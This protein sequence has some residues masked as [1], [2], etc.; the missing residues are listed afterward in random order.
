V[1][2]SKNKQRLSKERKAAALVAARQAAERRRRLV[3]LGGIGIAMVVIA[4]TV[5]VVLLSKDNG[6]SSDTADAAATTPPF[7]YGTGACA[8]VEGKPEK[9][10]LTFPGTNGFEKCVDPA[11][12]YTATFTTT[13]GTVVVQLD[14]ATQPG[15]VNNFVQLAG[16][17]YYDGSKLFRTDPSIGIVQGGAPQT[18]SATDP[19]PG[20]TIT[21]E[22]SGFTYQPGQ[23]VMARTPNP[24]SAGSQFFFTVTDASSKLDDAGT[25]VVFGS[26][27]TGLD[28]LEQI[29]ASNVEGTDGLGGSP[30]PP[31]T[32][33]S[34]VI[35]EG[36]LVGST[37]TSVN[38][39]TSTPVPSSTPSST[40]VPSSTSTP[41]SSS[42]S[43][44]VDPSV[45][46]PQST[47]STSIPA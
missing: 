19:G 36:R 30:N 7:T 21:D 13:A 39:S 46:T 8:P 26:V 2:T 35:G 4:V 10:Q 45:S 33:T 11:S 24:D 14:A 18:N 43:S 25:Y 38:P 9:P 6:S 27:M 3:I 44:T 16:Y 42:T 31:V 28:V 32:V 22:G 15:T 41:A 29:L 1:S 17:G 34:V 12:T 37:T 20:F 5:G 23:L 40:P 47:V